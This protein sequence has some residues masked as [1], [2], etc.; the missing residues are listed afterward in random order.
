[1]P[2]VTHQDLNLSGSNSARSHCTTHPVSAAAATAANS[3][4]RD[5]RAAIAVPRRGGGSAVLVLL[6]R[7]KSILKSIDDGLSYHLWHYCIIL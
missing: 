6:D 1:M 7:L 2:N 4:A 5:A 3:V